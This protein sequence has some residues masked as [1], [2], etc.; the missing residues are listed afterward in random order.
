MRH[1]QSVTRPGRRGSCPPD[2]IYRLALVARVR[3]GSPQRHC[4]AGRFRGLRCRQDAGR[5][6]AA[7]PEVLSTGDAPVAAY[8]VLPVSSSVFM[9][10]KIQA[11]PPAPISENLLATMSAMI[12]APSSSWVTVSL[13]KPDATFSISHVTR[14]KPSAFI[15]S[16]KR[17]R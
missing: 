9:S 2:A 5:K 16:L 13:E 15:A 11:Q 4:P 8:I 1:H 14:V 10:L 7:A 17:K 3:N 6:T 12:G